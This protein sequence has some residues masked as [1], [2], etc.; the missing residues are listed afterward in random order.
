MVDGN[1]DAP[2]LLVGM[3]P[4]RE[5]LAAARPFVGGSGRLLWA[6]MKKAGI[7][8]EDCYIVNIIGE[9]PEGAGGGPTRAQLDKY[10]DAFDSAVSRSTAKAVVC[11]GGDAFRRVSGIEGGIEQWRGYLV[12]PSECLTS[13]RS[14][15][16]VTTYKTSNTKKGYKKGDPRS[17]RTKA[18]YK[19][20]LPK[21]AD[22]IL[23]TLHPAGVMRSGFTNLPALQADL[24]RVRRALD[25]ELSY[26]RTSFIISPVIWHLEKG[27][28][29]AFDIETPRPPDDHVIERIGMA[30]ESGTWTSLWDAYSTEA[31]RRMLGAAGVVKVAHNIAFDLPRLEDYDVSIADP[32]FDT[33]LAAQML[34]PDL[35]KGLNAVTSLYL[36]RKRHKHEQALAPEHYNA[37][38][39][40]VTLELYTPLRDGLAVT[41]QLKLFTGTIMPTVRT[42]IKMTRRGIAVD[43]ARRDAWLV[44]LG[45]QERAL[46]EK[47]AGHSAVNV[48]SPQQVAKHL[49]GTLA[50]DRQYNK[51]GGT[52]VDAGALLSLKWLY[53]QH[54]EMLDTLIELK[55]VR[56]LRSTYAE[57]ALGADGCVHPSYL[58]ASK[59]Y[60]YV[61]AEGGRSYNKGMAG[62]GRLTARDPN[63]QNQPA[64]ARRLYIPHAPDLVLVAADY[65]QIELR[66]AAA[67]SKDDRLTEALAGD[68]H[69]RTQE[70]L[71]CDRVRAKN[72]IYGTLYGAGPRKLSQ[73]LKTKG[74]NVSEA[75]CRQLQDALARAYPKLWA[76]RQ[77][78]VSDVATNY[79]LSNPFGRRRYFLRGAEDAPAA[80]DFLPQSTAADIM[81]DVIAPVE[82]ALSTLG[83]AVLA[84]VHD[85]LLTEMPRGDVARGVEMLKAIMQHSFANI[86]P[87]FYVPISVK[88]GENWGEMLPYVGDAVS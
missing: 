73:V 61:D 27:A 84:T 54:A 85:E 62:T 37:N 22:W 18:P 31:A 65:S 47:W 76:W 82:N 6:L 30:T 60:E 1:P 7:R 75:E 63:I 15:V 71:G 34:Q 21:S 72:V 56:K 68:V 83:G 48:N 78:V 42:L 17:V 29:I 20:P 36:D 5:E 26:G 14:V 39:A 44:E 58:P 74:Y 8:R 45:Q 49:Y 23:P 11:L 28:A 64:A 19:T 55:K 35:Y 4:G 50:M 43:S 81:W 66:V 41:G 46:I 69:T 12:A 33:M 80:I 9:W 25:D 40:T 16:T 53:P 59:D 38:D 87:G 79:Y 3:A 10:W 57:Q 24:H 2:I 70:L 13:T 77:S 32:I 51:Y 67:L 52:A 86:A 88:V